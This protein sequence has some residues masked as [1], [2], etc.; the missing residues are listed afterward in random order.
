MNKLQRTVLVIEPQEE[1][2]LAIR[3]AFCHTVTSDYHVIE[4]ADDAQALIGLQQ[5]PDC[6]LLATKWRSCVNWP[7]NTPS[8]RSYWKA[9]PIVSSC[10]TSKAAYFR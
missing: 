2:R 1:E 9:A 8:T 5:Q 3:Q 6:L 7:H 10:L 4:A